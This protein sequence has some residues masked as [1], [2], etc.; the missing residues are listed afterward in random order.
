MPKNKFYSKSQILTGTK[1]DE[2]VNRPKSAEDHTEHSN[3]RTRKNMKDPNAVSLFNENALF[4]KSSNKLFSLL[5]GKTL[6]F[7]HNGWTKA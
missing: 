4:K 7:I 1:R 5:R 6:F 3:R 2:T